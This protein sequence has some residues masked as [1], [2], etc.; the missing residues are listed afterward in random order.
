MQLC[1]IKI[2][3]KKSLNFLSLFLFLCARC[4]SEYG[5]KDTASGVCPEQEESPGSAKP[6]PLP[7]QRPTLLVRVSVTA[8]L[9]KAKP[10]LQ[11]DLY[12]CIASSTKLK[13]I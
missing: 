2:G 12:K 11:W 7:A 10:G 9:S 1:E 5:G 8:L 6:K 13:F 4:S 3:G